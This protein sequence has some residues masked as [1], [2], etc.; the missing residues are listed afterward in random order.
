MSKGRTKEKKKAKK[1]TPPS[2]YLTMPHYFPTEQ[3]D[4]VKKMKSKRK[5][6]KK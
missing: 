2:S 3:I 4:I 6:K 5:R 1:R